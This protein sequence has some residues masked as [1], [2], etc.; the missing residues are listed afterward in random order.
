MAI[1]YGIIQN[2]NPSTT[3]AEGVVLVSHDN[4]GGTTGVT[5]GVEVFDTAP[6]RSVVVPPTDANGFTRS[7]RLLAPGRPASL[8]K[9]DA[10]LE[11]GVVLVQAGGLI[12]TALPPAS[13]STGLNF[14]LPRG[15]GSVFVLVGNP[16]L[17]SAIE[18][19]VHLG[20]LAAVPTAGIVGAGAVRRFDVP[21]ADANYLIQADAPVL[22]LA[23]GGVGVPAT[24]LTPL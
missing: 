11:A 4:S 8:V 1:H 5:I 17:T 2:L 3:D 9:V 24:L 21:T 6:P 16:D 15:G 20:G 22:V 19:R 12:A 14:L 13:K 7:P 10:P 23:A 18:A